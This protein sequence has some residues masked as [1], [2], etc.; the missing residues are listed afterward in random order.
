[1]QKYTLFSYAPN[2][3]RKKFWR[4]LESLLAKWQLTAVYQ[5]VKRQKKFFIF[6][7]L[8]G[9]RCTHWGQNYEFCTIR[10]QWKIKKFCVLCRRTCL[11]GAFGAY[12]ERIEGFGF[13]IMQ[14]YI[15]SRCSKLF[16]IILSKYFYLESRSCTAF[17][18]WSHASPQHSSLEPA[19][20]ALHSVCTDIALIRCSC[21]KTIEP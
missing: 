4:N 12:R 6:F 1:M 16:Y 18:L 8:M 13:K 17:T 9:A 3:S 14:I 20:V 7:G 21:F 2:F 10:T 19:L 11:M 5:T 15:I